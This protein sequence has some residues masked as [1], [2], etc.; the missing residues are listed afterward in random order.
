MALPNFAHQ[1]EAGDAWLAECCPYPDLVHTTWESEA[2]A[3]IAS[4]TRWLA[5]EAQ[6]ATRYDALARIPVE[7]RGPVLADLVQDKMWWLVPLS[8]AGE[9][10]GVRQLRVQPPGWSLHCPPT[11][12][13]LDGRTWLTRPDGSGQLT[14]A[15]ALAAA[16]GPGGY[17]RLPAEAS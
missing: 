7:L 17:R 2:L 3:P 15:A 10:A 5:A 13:H 8:A 9:L 14:D 12:W 11:G 1:Y 6:L 4:D 16:L